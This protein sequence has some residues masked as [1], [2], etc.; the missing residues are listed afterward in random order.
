MSSPQIFVEV[1][2]QLEML[3]IEDPKF[4]GE[5]HY[6][7]A[8]TRVQGTRYEGE[9]KVSYCGKFG[10]QVEYFFGP[11][12]RQVGK[13]VTSMGGESSWNDSVRLSNGEVM[14]RC[15]ELRGLG[16]GGFLFNR[17]VRWA[18][19]ADPQSAIVPLWLSGVDGESKINRD[20]RNRL[21]RRFGLRLN[22]LS[23][24]EVEG[25]SASDMKVGEL[26]DW[27]DQEWPK[28]RS[29]NW[30]QGWHE[31]VGQYQ[32]TRRELRQS[33]RVARMYRL[34][35]N[36]IEGHIKTCMAHLRVAV[37]WP[38]AVVFGVAGFILGSQHVPEWVWSLWRWLST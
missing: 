3:R 22:F 24:D 25:R 23:V 4:P 5:P 10:V 19:H 14:I 8:H 2:E 7:V 11:L 9:K 38:L 18:K 28:I 12:Q 26:I 27:P 20:R 32:M 31:L 16:L 15:E 35:V 36:R 1:T 17:I 37:S 6:L 13:A 33:R 21:Y 29:S 30:N 34:K